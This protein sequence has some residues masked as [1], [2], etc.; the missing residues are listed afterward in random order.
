MLSKRIK[1]WNN[2]KQNKFNIRE[3]K[4]KNKNIRWAQIKSVSP[5]KSARKCPFSTCIKSI[6]ILIN[7]KT[8][9]WIKRSKINF[10]VVVK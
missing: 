4:T 9:K 2:N 10:R 8:L 6:I 1:Q 5:Y 3:N 7:T